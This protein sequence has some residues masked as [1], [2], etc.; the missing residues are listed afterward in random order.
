M[1]KEQQLAEMRET[2]LNAEKNLTKIKNE[3]NLLNGNTKFILIV[4]A[5]MMNWLDDQSKLRSMH[6]AEIVR[7]LIFNKMSRT[8]PQLN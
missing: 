7:A 1:S 8:K 6:K 3:Y 5:K 2:I 4:P